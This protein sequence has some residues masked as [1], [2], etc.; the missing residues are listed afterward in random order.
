MNSRSPRVV[1]GGI[2]GGGLV[3]FLIG[4]YV[5]VLTHDYVIRSDDYA[6]PLQYEQSQTRFASTVLLAFIIVF[7][8]IGPIIAFAS[9]GTWIRHAVYG[10]VSAIG[11]VVIVALIAAAITNQQPF[12]TMKGSQRTCIDIACTYAVP[13]AII[14][15]PG[16]GILAARFLGCRT[17]EWIQ[18]ENAN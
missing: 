17:D 1:I 8:S 6:H 18:H 9:F 12:N 15:G 13:A 7:A 11:M 10:M 2:L 14:L 4:A 3:G 5:V 16:A